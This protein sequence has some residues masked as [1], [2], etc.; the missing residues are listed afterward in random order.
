MKSKL[1]LWLL[2]VV[3]LRAGRWDLAREYAQERIE[4]AEML[5]EEDPNASIPLALVAAYQGEESEARAL[6]E[7]G[8]A[9]AEAADNAFVAGFQRAVCW[10]CSR[11]GQVTALARSSS[12]Q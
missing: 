12:S 9:L 2:A 3:E 4:L 10:V 8:I 5:G 1:V 6:A 11:A 7:R